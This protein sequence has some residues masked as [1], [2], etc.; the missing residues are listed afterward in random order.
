MSDNNITVDAGAVTDGAYTLFVADFG[1][2]DAA[3]QAYEAIKEA[4]DG[5]AFDIEGILVVKR[6]ADGNVEIQKATDH[7]T[8]RG[9][10]WGVVGG[11]A[12]GL[13]FPPSILGSAAALGVVG[14]AAGKGVEL[15]HRKELTEDLQDS[16]APGHSGI[17]ALVSDPNAVELRRQL[18]KAE[19]I[20]EKALDKAEADE[21]KAAADA[22]SAEAK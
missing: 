14:A 3:W 11:V 1:N 8:R 18:D 9:L 6:D 17:V 10:A 19:A 22:A 12:L 20:A 16:I 13:I 7:S 5:K 21:I 15:H 2:T 4:E